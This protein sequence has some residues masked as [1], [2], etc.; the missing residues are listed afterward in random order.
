MIAA[1]SA[2]Q[3]IERISWIATI[4]V[5]AATLVLLLVAGF[6]VV[7]SIEK[8]LRHSD[9]DLGFKDGLDIDAP[10]ITNCRLRTTDSVQP[11]LREAEITFW[12]QNNGNGSATGLVYNYC[13]PESVGSPDLGKQVETISGKSIVVSALGGGLNLI[14]RMDYLHPKTAHRDT[15]KIWVAPSTRDFDVKASLY[16]TDREPI[17]RQLHVFLDDAPSSSPVEELPQPLPQTLDAPLAS[18]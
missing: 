1:T 12:S 18:A 9:L 3:W 10:V 4:L 15:I 7:E 14:S 17:M 5:L 6:Q 8:Y 13:L 16:R 2:W 11:G